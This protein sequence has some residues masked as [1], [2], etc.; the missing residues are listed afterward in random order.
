MKNERD[1]KAEVKKLLKAHGAWFFMPSMNG[2]GRSG[3]PDFIGCSRS[4]R[5]FAIETKFGKNKL[6]V[7][8][9]VELENIRM[10]D[11]ETFVCYETDLE[12]LTEWLEYLGD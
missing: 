12:R 1:V 4:G 9:E 2:Y 6:S 3:V 7:G 10:C 5:F 11:G 8:Q